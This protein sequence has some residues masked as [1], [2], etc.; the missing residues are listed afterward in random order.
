MNN[1]RQLTKDEYP[2]AIELSWQVFTITGKE[3]F[4]N[5]G[6]EFFKSFIYNKKCINEIIFYGSFD[7]EALT[8]IQLL[9]QN[10]Y[11]RLCHSG[12]YKYYR[13]EN[14]GHR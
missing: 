8:G 6:L 1:I 5:E 11:F 14:A 10:F 2:K 7:N 3:D 13:T 4:N 12:Y 9:W